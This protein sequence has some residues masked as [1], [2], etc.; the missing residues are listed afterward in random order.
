MKK[1]IL[2]MAVVAFSV[3]NVQAQ[4]AAKSTTLSLGV[5][6]GIPTTTGLSLAYGADLQADFAVAATTKITASAGYEDYSVKGGGSASGVVPILA[7]AKF[8]LG[9]DNLYGHAQLGYVVS[10]A[11]GGGGAFG[12]APSIGYYF[13]PNFDASIKYLAYSKNSFTTGSVNLRLAYNF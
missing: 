1:L 11:K 2:A 6:V 5:N 9:S 4:D 8:N 13:S 7:G 10:T 3:A 12:Y